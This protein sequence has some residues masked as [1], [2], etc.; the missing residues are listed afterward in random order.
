MFFKLRVFRIT[1]L[2][3]FVH[4]PGILNTRKHNVTELD[5]FPCSLSSSVN[6]GKEN[7]RESRAFIFRN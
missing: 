3:V 6:S 4:R 2:L 1:G 7:G 5:L